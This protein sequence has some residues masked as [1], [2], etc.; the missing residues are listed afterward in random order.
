MKDF[1]SVY[2][3]KANYYR[4]PWSK[5]DNPIGWLEV[6]DICN[7][8]CKGCYRQTL[9]GHKSLDEIKNEILFFKTWRNCDNIS[10]AGGEPLIHPD[11]ERIVEF[12]AENGMKPIVLS[13]A[14]ALTRD[15]L[16]TLKKAGLAGLTLH[17]DSLQ[18]R[19]KW[20]GKSEIELN[21]LRQHYAE[22]I[23]EEK[24]LY[25]SFNSTIYYANFYDIPGIMAWATEN[26]DKVNGIIF[27]TYRGVPI[28]PDV[29]YC[30]GD[31]HIDAVEDLSYT[32]EDLSEIDITSTDVYT[33]L[34]NTLST[35]EPCGYLGGTVSHDA[36]KWFVGSIIGSK[37]HVYG[38]IGKRT[39]E[40]TQT[41]HHFFSGTYVAYPNVSRIGKVVFLLSGIDKTIRKAFGNFIKRA[42]RSPV[43]AFRRV[44]LQSVAIIQAPDMIVGSQADMCDSCPD[45]TV[46][47]GKLINSCRMDEYRKFGGLISPVSCKHKE[48]E[49]SEV[50]GPPSHVPQPEHVVTTNEQ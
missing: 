45:M 41:L 42:L 29:E 36:Y 13:N 4:L 10:I 35:Y 8:H 26:I 32:T 22:M 18:N 1:E 31:S 3:P 7:I 40:L 5:N 9:S 43:D 30:V 15:K 11:I 16:R 50:E 38:S 24:R 49:K 23:S 37:N 2:P 28:R 19:P 25:C 14:V 48:E 20:K 12:I 34:K 33:I 47:D 39:M 44:H 27:I 17:I 21:E 6:T 46:Y